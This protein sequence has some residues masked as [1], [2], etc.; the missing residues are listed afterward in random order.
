MQGLFA[1]YPKLK[2]ILIALSGAITTVA[3]ITTII[4]I[5]ISQQNPYGVGIGINNIHEILPELPKN[6]VD[7][8]EHQLYELVLK[9]TP[10]LDTPNNLDAA[11]RENTIES[12]VDK[13][14]SYTSFII[15]INA[16]GQSYSAQAEWGDDD[17]ISG[18]PVIVTCVYD[19]AFIIYPS[20]SCQ[21]DFYDKSSEAADLA[22]FAVLQLLPYTAQLSNGYSYTVT[23]GYWKNDKPTLKITVND[24]GNQKAL[25]A[26]LD[27]TKIWLNSSGLDPNQFE[28]ETISAYINCIIE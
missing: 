14:I 21:D 2:P 5:I 18:Y 20:F 15:D 25:G 3:I 28:Y 1:N 12:N 4:I 13:N 10:D 8:I 16:L 7:N 24:C 23:S 6:Q 17:L 9:N 22:S 27:A 11:I 26:A 19:K